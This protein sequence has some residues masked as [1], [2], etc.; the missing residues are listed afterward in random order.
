MFTVIYHEVDTL[1][2]RFSQVQQTQKK[3][4]QA[5]VH[6]EESLLQEYALREAQLVEQISDLET[7]LKHSRQNIER[8]T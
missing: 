6:A 5:G 3:A 8:W 1:L 7:E 4:T 2:Q